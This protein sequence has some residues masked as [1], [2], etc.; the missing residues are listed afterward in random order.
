VLACYEVKCS[1]LGKRLGRLREAKPQP[2][3]QAF[4]RSAEVPTGMTP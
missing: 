3:V 4:R 2:G 1:E